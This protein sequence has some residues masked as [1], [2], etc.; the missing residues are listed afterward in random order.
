MV[1]KH[2]FEGLVGW[3]KAEIESLRTQL[4]PLEDGTMH[5]GKRAPKGAWEDI[6][7]HRIAWLKEKMVE[8]DDLII[9]YSFEV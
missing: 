4:A 7:A 2:E 8:L 5:L 1:P 9:Q 6:T 3:C